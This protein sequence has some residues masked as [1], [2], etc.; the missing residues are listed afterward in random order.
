MLDGVTTEFELSAYPP[1][2]S[3]GSR[4]LVIKAARGKP[5]PQKK[6][7][8]F[9]GIGTSFEYNIHNSD[10]KNLARGLLERLFYVKR[11]GEFTTPFA[12][13][14]PAVLERL[15]SIRREIVKNVRNATPM[16]RQQFVDGYQARRRITY[17]GAMESLEHTPVSSKDSMV[18]TFTK[19]EKVNFTLKHDPAP[20]IIQPRDARYNVCLGVYIKPIEHRLYRSVAKLFGSDTIVK[21]LNANDV[22]ALAWKKW[23]S[24]KHPIAIG[25]DASRFDQHVSRTML[26]DF[27][28][29]IYVGCYPREQEKKELKSLLKQQLINKGR[30][31]I[32]DKRIEYSVEGCR[33]SGDM[34]TGL[35][36]CLIASAMVYAFC[37]NV[38]LTKRELLN[39]GDDCVLFIERSELAKMESLPGYMRDFGFDFIVEQPVEIFERIEF[40]QSRFVFVG[41][42]YRQIRNP[43]VVAC[44]DSVTAIPHMTTA[45]NLQGLLGSLGMGGLALNSGVPV[46]QS[47][48]QCYT[49]S[50]C[51]RVLVG[52]PALETGTRIL[53]RG[54]DSAVVPITDQSRYS[55]WLATGTTP[56]E[57][58]ELEHYYDHFTITNEVV[59]NVGEDVL[60][61]LCGS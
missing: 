36:N 58:V 37:Q 13:S 50:S 8:K 28:H 24:F 25:M 16:S 40:C 59:P 30:V 23:T 42:N 35:G 15:D 1:L 39:N 11:D 4:S 51:G 27:E 57:Q 18:K 7:Y 33:M 38:G 53:A 49:R 44:K 22:G 47:L 55:Y 54:M 6:I 2:A 9:V 29:R 17:Q 5:K 46:L 14:R 60:H 52:H 32:E 43:E 12:C 19:S 45:K 20:R 26:E 21:G 10:F 31:F 34:N 41:N 48:Y 56:D 3:S 61:L